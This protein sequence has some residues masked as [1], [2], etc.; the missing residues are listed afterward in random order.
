M[1]GVVV[2]DGVDDP[3]GP[4]STLDGVE[5]FDELLVGMALHATANHGAVEDVEGG[6]QGGGAVALVVMGHG[7]AFA[8]LHG[9]AG[10]GAVERLDW[11]FLVNRD[12]HGMNGW[13][14]VEAD[15][16]FTFA[17]NAGSRDVLKVRMRWG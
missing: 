14:H 17:A 13:I 6:E 10:L 4:D 1:G 12:D 8:G 11:G 15:D 16:D 3:A 9:Q 7:A 5:E 2:G